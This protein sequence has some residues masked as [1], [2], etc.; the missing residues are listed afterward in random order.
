MNALDSL[1]VKGEMNV[2]N[3]KFINAATASNAIVNV[4]IYYGGVE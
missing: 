4:A 1:P 2:K 3:L